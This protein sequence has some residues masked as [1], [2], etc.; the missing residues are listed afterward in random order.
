MHVR[1]GSAHRRSGRPYDID[2]GRGSNVTSLKARVG[3]LMT[4]AAVVI[5]PIVIA[6]HL[7]SCC[8]TKPISMAD[9]AGTYRSEMK[10]AYVH[11]AMITRNDGTSEY[12]EINEQRPDL[13]RATL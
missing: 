6:G 8:R 12:K 2:V 10:G 7:Y 13:M 5:I 9:M 4:I 11:A 1:R 3:R